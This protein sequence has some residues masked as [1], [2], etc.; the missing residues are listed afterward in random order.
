MHLA[1]CAMACSGSVSLELLHH[2]TP[3]VILYWVNRLAYRVQDA[4]RT[5]KYIT[6]VNLLAEW[7]RAQGGLR[8][9]VPDFESVC[10]RRKTGPAALTPGPS[11]ADR[12]AVGGRGETCQIPGPDSLTPGPTPGLSQATGGRGELFPEYLTCEDRSAAIAGHVVEWLTDA[13]KRQ[14][15]VAELERLK[16]QVAAGGASARAAEYVLQ[17][18]RKKG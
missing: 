17:R 3:T 2:T 12:S 1:A 11:P 6:L 5:V 13:G 8:G 16:A 14:R 9:Q 18:M 7:E 15:C 10:F 4:F